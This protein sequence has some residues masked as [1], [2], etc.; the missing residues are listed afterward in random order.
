MWQNEFAKAKLQRVFATIRLENY[1]S[2]RDFL[3][4]E[5]P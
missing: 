2:L 4:I 5:R 3:D 1:F